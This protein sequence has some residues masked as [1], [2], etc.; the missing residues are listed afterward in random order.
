MIISLKVPDEVYEKYGHYNPQNPRLAMEQA[1]VRY[2]DNAPNRKAIN[3]QGD[4]L[5]EVQKLLGGVYDSPESFLQDL[6][7]VLTVKVEG[8][9]VGLTDGQRKTIFTYVQHM[10]GHAD[11]KDFLLVKIKEGLRLALGV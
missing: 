7:R 8:V 9:E 3:L 2:Q 1:L 11:P 4:A 10:G 6:R 5:A